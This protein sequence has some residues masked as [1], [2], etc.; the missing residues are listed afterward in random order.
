MNQKNTITCM[1][2]R[3]LLEYVPLLI[4]GTWAD[5]IVSK[6]RE[7]NPVLY[8]EMGRWREI[9]EEEMD[10]VNKEILTAAEQVHL[11]TVDDNSN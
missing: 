6:F 11:E 5:R 10:A 9:P 3:R 2:P 7:N 8:A 4:R 1:I